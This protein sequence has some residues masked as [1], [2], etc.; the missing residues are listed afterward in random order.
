MVG[1]SSQQ[2]LVHQLVH[3]G[4]LQTESL[5]TGAMLQV[6]RSLYG[7]T[8][9][10]C[11]QSIGFGQTISAPH[12][13]A[14]A[15]SVLE[16]ALTGKKRVRILDIGC[17]SGYLTVALARLGQSTGMA[18]DVKVIGIESVRELVG[19]AIENIRRA[20]GDLLDNG[21]VE[22]HLHD[23]WKGFQTAAPFDAIHVGAAADHVPDTLKH[24]L[25]IGGQLLIPVGDVAF[26]QTLFRCFKDS[27]GSV[28]CEP[29]EGV[30]FV[31]L[32]KHPQM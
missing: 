3:K 14:Q 9:E 4:V 28:H 15:L 30:I 8:F 13:H 20:D 26:D 11:P 21:I 5:A 29:L 19:K 12:M 18:E 7:G 6:D 27:H 16:T 1:A 32:V 24:Q 25:A 17:G 22:I 10:D 31:P 2:G 23:G